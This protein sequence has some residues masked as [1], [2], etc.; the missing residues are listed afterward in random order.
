MTGAGAK[1][2]TTLSNEGSVGAAITAAAQ[3]LAAAGVEGARA[4]ARRLVEAAAGL[5]RERLLGW[6]ET[7]LGPEAVERLQ[8]MVERRAAR[9]PLAYVLGRR[10]FYGREFLVDPGVLVPRPETETLVDA[11]RK[12]FPD[13]GAALRVL[14]MGVG[15]GCLLLTVLSL[16][17][18]ATGVGTDLSEAALA[19]ASANARALGV[20]ERAELRR[21]AWAEGVEGPFDLALSNPP[22]VRDGDIA[23]L[24]PEVRDWEPRLAL[25][26]GADG[27][28]AYRDLTPHLV[29]VLGPGGVALLEIGRGQEGE[30]VPWLEGAGLAV[31]GQRDLAGVVRCLALRRRGTS[32]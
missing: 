30:L 15:T 17:P 31:E 28:E 27:L 9:E 13:P 23:G 8:R 18:A 11:A 22:Y 19:C 4:E 20:A 29:R 7:P 12:M 6:P 21:T 32:V 14:D 1:A 3:R 16:Y 26:G 25:A 10:E 5:T 2:V 24:E